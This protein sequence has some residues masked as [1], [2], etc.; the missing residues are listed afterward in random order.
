[1]TNKVQLFSN[2]V[3]LPLRSIILFLLFTFSLFYLVHQASLLK[4][5]L[6]LNYP[7]TLVTLHGEDHKN[8]TKIAPKQILDQD[9][10]ISD[11]DYI[12]NDI[13]DDYWFGELP[14]EPYAHIYCSGTFR[15]QTII[16]KGSSKDFTFNLNSLIHELEKTDRVCVIDN[17]ASPF[18]TI[19]LNNEIGL[20]KVI[21]D[22]S[23]ELKP[24]VFVGK[25]FGAIFTTKFV[26]EYKQDIKKV[27]LINPMENVPLTRLNYKLLQSLSKFGILKLMKYSSFY[28]DLL[29]DIPE[30]FYQSVQSR[31]EIDHIINNPKFWK[32]QEVEQFSFEQLKEEIKNITSDIPTE[33]I[34]KDLKTPHLY[35]E[36]FKNSKI[37]HNVIE[38]QKIAS[39]IIK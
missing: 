20:Y 4:N 5:T 19:D 13:D 37:H 27:I 21:L 23:N 39:I 38:P 15:N 30:E 2:Y 25:E 11:S 31:T 29:G 34:S 8:L 9:D 7:G 3:F 16:L 35:V 22:R 12:I 32:L 18:T 6:E 36:I 1:M 24:F 17:E 10:D 28:H 33:I 26:N 14:K